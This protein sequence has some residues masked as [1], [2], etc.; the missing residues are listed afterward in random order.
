MG[1]EPE[2]VAHGNTNA[3]L[4]VVDSCDAHPKTLITGQ[5]LE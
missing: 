4:P 3:G 1:H 5:E 2:V